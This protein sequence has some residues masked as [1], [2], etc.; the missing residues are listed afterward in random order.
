[1]M[2]SADDNLNKS[3]DTEER[4]ELNASLIYCQQAVS[5]C[6][7]CLALTLPQSSILSF[8]F[9]SQICSLAT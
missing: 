4:N 9:I 3:L 6:R 7:I 5:K 8:N 1:M 2:K